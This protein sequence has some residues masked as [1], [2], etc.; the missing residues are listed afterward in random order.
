VE[1]CF[2]VVVDRGRPSMRVVVRPL[3]TFAEGSKTIMLA[4]AS[5]LVIA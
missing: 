5:G 2:I 1:T 4:H 3:R